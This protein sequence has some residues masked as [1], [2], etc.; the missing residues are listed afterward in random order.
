MYQITEEQGDFD[1]AVTGVATTPVAIDQALS[2]PI[3]EKD[4][5][6]AVATYLSGAIDDVQALNLSM[7]L[8][9]EAYKEGATAKSLQR[10]QAATLLRRSLCRKHGISMTPFLVVESLAN[11]EGLIIALEEEATQQKN[12]FR[13]IWDSIMNAFKWLWEKLT[14]LFSKKPTPEEDKKA[15]DGI[16][17]ALKKAKEDGVDFKALVVEGK[18]VRDAY[19]FLGNTLTAAMLITEVETAQKHLVQLEKLLE[20]SDEVFTFLT[21]AA[22]KIT[23]STTPEQHKATMQEASGMVA[24]HLTG[25]EKLSLEELKTAIDLKDTSDIDNNDIRG[26][27]GCAYGK[28]LAVYHKN[29]SDGVLMYKAKLSVAKGDYKDVKADVPDADDCLTLINSVLAFILKSSDV[30]KRFSESASDN[31]NKQTKLKG[32][33]EKMMAADP[34]KPEEQKSV[35]A[36]MSLFSTFSKAVGD[37]A[38]AAASGYTNTDN[39]VK[40]IKAYIIDISKAVAKV[41]TEKKEDEKPAEAKPEDAADDKS[42]A[43]PTEAAKEE[44][45]ETKP[46][47]SNR[48][49]SEIDVDGRKVTVSTRKP[50]VKAKK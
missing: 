2:S 14:S 30:A 20:A 15:L 4:G 18:T 23:L 16:D 3:T 43:K 13:R 32:L 25:Y 29:A 8:V 21:N 19:G 47:E 27:K 36:T 28:T 46:K 6:E 33:V 45:P 42:E 9:Q 26:L 12:I 17:A 37:F 35:K 40:T 49:E 10:L 11:K 24:K 41:K 1:L 22:S 50:K 34:E 48:R 7:S 5:V 31:T 39:G 44:T 38:I